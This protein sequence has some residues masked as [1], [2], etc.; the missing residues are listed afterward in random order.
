MN[1]K[2]EKQIVLGLLIGVLVLVL[3]WV[4][5]GGRRGERDSLRAANEVLEA[6]V[7]KGT[8]L[9]ASYEKLKDEVAQQEKRIE[10]LV[11]LLPQ[12]QDRLRIQHF[13]QKLASTAGLGQVQKW[14][15]SS[16]ERKDYVTEYPAIFQYSTGFHQ[17]GQFLSLV[18]GYDKII[19]ISD[20]SLVRETGR[21]GNSAMATFKLSLFVYNPAPP[22]AEA[23]A[24][25]R[26]PRAGASKKEED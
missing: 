10:E 6:E 3:V 13:I 26:T 8:Q 14:S 18:T 7:V 19:N 5:L 11:K 15:N 17:F 20:I 2:I 23:P 22:E 12:E 16:P 24:K 4:L 21:I 9:K 1:I 25:P